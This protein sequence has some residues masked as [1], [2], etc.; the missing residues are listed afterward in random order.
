[1]RHSPHSGVAAVN[2]TRAL[3]VLLVVILVMTLST[4]SGKAF[5]WGY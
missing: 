2:K 4:V 3:G 5:A 1:M